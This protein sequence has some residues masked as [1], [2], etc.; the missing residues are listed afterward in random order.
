VIL[1]GDVI[2]SHSS[3]LRL[4]PKRDPL[5]PCAYVG[6]TGIPVAHR[7]QNHKNSYKSAGIVRRYGVRLMPE[8]YER[9]NPMP[10]E[11]AVQMELELAQDLGAAG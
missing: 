7:F 10:F 5:K 6:K 3:V 4:N 8:L 9:L 11:A 2:A 1:L